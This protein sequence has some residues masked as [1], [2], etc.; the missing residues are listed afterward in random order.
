MDAV[1]HRIIQ[2]LKEDA[3]MPFL[4]IAKKL[5]VSEG[6]IRKRVAKMINEGVIKKFTAVLSG[7]ATVIIEVSTHSGRPTQ[8]IARQIRKMNVD[9][10]YEVAGRYSIF[11]TV[12]RNSLNEVNDI[13][14]AI[15]ALPG[16]I[17]TETF[18]VLKED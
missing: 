4:Q 7:E 14:E 10:I 9:E 16:V 17:Q 15:R 6:T 11:V 2:M 18:P 12:K 8:Q 5:K 13:V 3:R 1:D